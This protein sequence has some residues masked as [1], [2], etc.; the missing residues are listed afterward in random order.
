MGGS[1]GG[2]VVEWFGGWFVNALVDL[3]MN[4]GSID[5]YMKFILL[6]CGI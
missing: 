5:E 6:Y 3:F 1:V 2:W 4:K